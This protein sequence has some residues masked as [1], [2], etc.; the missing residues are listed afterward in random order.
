MSKDMV[1]ALLFH[2]FEKPD[3]Y[4]EEMA[5]FLWDEFEVIA[6]TSLISRVLKKADWSKKIVRHCP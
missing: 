1:E 5:W 6:S 3:L 4:L 2:L